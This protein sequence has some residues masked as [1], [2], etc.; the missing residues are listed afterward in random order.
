MEKVEFG[1]KPWLHSCRI[2]LHHKC[3][4]W[5]LVLI[6]CFRVVPASVT[7]SFN[8]QNYPIQ[9]VLLLPCAVGI[10]A[11]VLDVVKDGVKHL[12]WDF[13][14]SEWQSWVLKW[15]SWTWESTAFNYFPL[16]LT[17]CFGGRARLSTKPRTQSFLHKLGTLLDD[18]N[19]I[20]TDCL[21]V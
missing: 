17:F 5:E 7:I 1:V 16:H 20:L 10:I 3:I 21:W 2:I 15:E 14:A 18:A 11:P 8:S 9:Q 4:S 6:R 19:Q 13:S 12:S